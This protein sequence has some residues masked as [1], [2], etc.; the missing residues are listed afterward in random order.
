MAVPTFQELMLPLLQQGAVKPTAVREAVNLM[1]DRFDLTPEERQE[2]LP[3]KA[4]TRLANRTNWA[5]SY[6]VRADLLERPRRA[7]FEITDTGRA[8]LAT[9]PDYI[10]VKFLRENY[11]TFESK[12]EGGEPDTD[13]AGLADKASDEETT[14]QERIDS[15]QSEIELA[16]RSDVLNQVYALDPAL[17]E[18]LIVDLMLAMGYGEGGEGRRIGQAGDGGIDGI[19]SEDQ[20][21]LDVVYLQA[22]RY[23]PDNSIGPEQVRG[24][25]GALSIRRASKGVFV[26]TSRFT[27]AAQEEAKMSGQRV[28]LIDGKRLASLMIQYCVGVRVKETVLIKELDLNYFDDA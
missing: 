21:G 8:L 25:I 13:D 7:W 17:F 28:I 23:A 3:S 6:L 26:T 14:P 24:F 20:L 2:I 16:L 22:K 10:D 12:L 19:I 11:R 1:A 18:E 15:A 4:Q 9:S 27:A 5:V